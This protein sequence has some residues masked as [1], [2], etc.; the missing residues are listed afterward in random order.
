MV[1]AK[2][3]PHVTAICADANSPLLIAGGSNGTVV[4]LD[5]RTHPA[6][7]AVAQF[8]G[9]A[10]GSPI[11]SVGLQSCANPWLASGSAAGEIKVWDPRRVASASA[12]PTSTGSSPPAA[13][14]YSI[15]THKSA[16]SV[17]ALHP[18][19]PL[20]AS[21]SRNQFI[22]LFDLSTLRVQSAAR[23]ISTIRYF[24]G[25]LGARIGPVTTLAFHP[26]KVL[27]GVGATD[28]VISLYS[29]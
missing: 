17:L 10:S 28:T 7:S 15:T 25:F 12:A 2:D 5:P 16:L 4:A 26:Q 22:K 24:D 19:V 20:L 1:G 3:G 13:S 27:L 21:G 14:L 23:E 6:S 9:S 29:A 11:V 8:A 18:T